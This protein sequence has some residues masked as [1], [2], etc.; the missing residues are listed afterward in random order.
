MAW[1]SADNGAE[2]GCVERIAVAC[3]SV[4][5]TFWGLFVSTDEGDGYVL[6]VTLVK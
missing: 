2:S 5:W 6:A 1:E 3:V 4:I